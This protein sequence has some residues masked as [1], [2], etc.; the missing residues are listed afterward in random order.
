VKNSLVEASPFVNGVLQPSATRVSFVIK[1]ALLTVYV[2]LVICFM[3]GEIHDQGSSL[4]EISSRHEVQVD[5][6]R[7]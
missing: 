3:S 6:L 5:A 1:I 7:E 2:V 4:D